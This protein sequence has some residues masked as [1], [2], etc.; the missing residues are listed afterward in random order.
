MTQL[1]DSDFV[2]PKG[3]QSSDRHTPRAPFDH[4]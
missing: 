4:I 3:T 2:V 1:A